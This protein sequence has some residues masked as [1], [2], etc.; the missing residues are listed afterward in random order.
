MIPGNSDCFYG[1]RE[2]IKKWYRFLLF[3]DMPTDQK[4]FLWENT[5]NHL[6]G[7]HSYCLP[8]EHTDFVW[9]NGIDHPEVSAKLDEIIKSRSSDFDKIKTGLSTQA[10]ESFHETQLKY[11]DKGHRYPVS[12]ET[13]DYLA[14]LAWN[15][16]ET[17]E[18][19]LRQRLH[20]SGLDAH[21]DA[22]VQR[23]IESRATRSQ[24][25]RESAYRR[26]EANYRAERARRNKPSLDDHY[27]MKN[28]D[29]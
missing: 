29:E 20:L 7:N 13:R 25:R 15:E 27:K 21:Y 2:K 9:G 11:G 4:K 23:G 28:D 18:R 26:A 5:T 10:N 8:H 16:R 12:Q 24:T 17:F 22:I 6:R 19:E 14:V 3:T 1:I